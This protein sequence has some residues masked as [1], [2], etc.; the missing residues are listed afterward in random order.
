MSQNRKYTVFISSTYEDLKHERQEVVKAC[1]EMGHIPIGMEMFSAANESQWEVIQRTIAACDY[2]VVI[3]ATRYGST[4]AA[5]DGISYTEKEYDYAVMQELPVLGF[6]LDASASWPENKRETDP[7]KQERLQKF[8]DKVRS[9]MASHWSNDA[10]LRGKFAI[11]LSKAFE[12]HPRAGWVPSTQAASPE[13]SNVIAR[14]SSENERLRAELDEFEEQPRE[15]GKQDKL[16]ERLR[17][18]RTRSSPQS[19]SLY[20]L[21]RVVGGR[22]YTHGDLERSVRGC[23]LS[24][25]EELGRDAMRLAAF[26]LLIIALKKKGRVS[27][28]THFLTASGKSLVH[29]WVRERALEEQ[30][31]SSSE[32]PQS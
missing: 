31:V 28:L 24:A 32:S 4:I 2:Y 14:L 1:L 27:S 11:A 22:L 19:M 3:L 13:V 12:Q 30:T 7:A 5:E 10:D 8:K 16:I 17:T 20:D 6:V 26:G 9:K 21:F 15:S 18:I 25:P 23:N 29:R